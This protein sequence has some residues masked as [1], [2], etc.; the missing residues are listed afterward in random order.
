MNEIP[1]QVKVY[2]NIPY[3]DK[4]YAKELGCKW[5]PE[6]KKWYSIDSDRGKSNISEVLKIWDNPEPYKILDGKKIPISNL[7]KNQRGFTRIY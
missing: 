1:I 2:L 4:E 7:T 3:K 6:E 5:D